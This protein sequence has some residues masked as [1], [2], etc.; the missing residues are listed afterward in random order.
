MALGPASARKVPRA[1]N[2]GRCRFLSNC[3]GRGWEKR[4]RFLGLSGIWTSVLDF[5]LGDLMLLDLLI[6]GTSRNI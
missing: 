1:R 4:E 5:G 3:E 6:E 2:T